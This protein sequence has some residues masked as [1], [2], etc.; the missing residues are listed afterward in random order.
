MRNEV[1][2]V[3]LLG[4]GGSAKALEYQSEKPI[5]KTR[6]SKNLEKTKSSEQK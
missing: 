1:H 6:G 4:T 3:C 2:L 5:Y